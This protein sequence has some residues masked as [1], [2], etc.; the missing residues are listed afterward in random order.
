MAESWPEPDLPVADQP[1]PESWP[2]V[3]QPVVGSPGPEVQEPVAESWPEVQEPVAESWP[4]VQE[5]VAESWP[6]VQEPVAA[7]G[8][9]AAGQPIAGEAAAYGHWEAAGA[10]PTISQEA[11]AVPVAN[12]PSEGAPH[13]PLD[14]GAGD[15]RSGPHRYRGRRPLDRI[16]RRWVRPG[17]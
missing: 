3:D 9:P 11:V 6:V 10:P 7:N 16:S 13:G 4:E 2:V 5:P 17:R 12:G 8:R 1:V 15:Q 14:P